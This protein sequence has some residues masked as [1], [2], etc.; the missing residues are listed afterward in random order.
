M[1]EPNMQD[2]VINQ[3]VKEKAEKEECAFWD[4]VGDTEV[5]DWYQ[6]MELDAQKWER[7]QEKRGNFIEDY[8][9]RQL[10]ELCE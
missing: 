10:E 6:R 5:D 4:S 9:Q 2:P 7:D 3:D 8:R 1:S